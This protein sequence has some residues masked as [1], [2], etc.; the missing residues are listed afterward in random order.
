M[1]INESS[2]RART[3]STNMENNN[4]STLEANIKRSDRVA[5]EMGAFSVALLL[6]LYVVLSVF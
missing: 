4:T 6:V 2:V 5:L 3:I 1:S